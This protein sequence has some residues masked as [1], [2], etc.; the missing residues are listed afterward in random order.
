[1]AQNTYDTA[2][3]WIVGGIVVVL[4]LVAF[5]IWRPMTSYE[6][7]NPGAGT[8]TPYVD[9]SSNSIMPRGSTS[10]PESKSPMSYDN[11]VTPPSD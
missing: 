5:S 3:Y 2:M 8:S 10:M 4:A 9:E 6:D 11:E 7:I 1:M